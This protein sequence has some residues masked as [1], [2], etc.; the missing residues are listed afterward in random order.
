MRGRRRGQCA[1]KGADP[2]TPPPAIR[3]IAPIGITKPELR[4]EGGESGKQRGEAAVDRRYAAAGGVG[5]MGI[6]GIMGIMPR[7]RRSG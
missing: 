1:I 7:K 4:N 6:M 3:R 2:R 5:S